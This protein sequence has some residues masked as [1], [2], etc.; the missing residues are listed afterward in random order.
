MIRQRIPPSEPGHR[1]VGEVLESIQ[2]A[3]LAELMSIWRSRVPEEGSD[4]PALFRCLGERILTQGEPLLAY[5][6]V[7]AGLTI[8]PKD[9]RLRQLQGLALAAHKWLYRDGPAKPTPILVQILAHWMR[10][11]ATLHEQGPQKQRTKTPCAQSK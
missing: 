4:S 3:S 7:T 9:T 1:D 5:D 6:V 2:S 8:W 10:L 11:P